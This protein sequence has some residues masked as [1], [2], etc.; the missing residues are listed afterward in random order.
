MKPVRLEFNR[1]CNTSRTEWNDNLRYSASLNL[2]VLSKMQSPPHERTLAIVGGG[3]STLAG[4]DI[5]RRWEGDVWG[6]N[7]T[8]GWL[9]RKGVSAT[10]FSIDALPVVK[11]QIEGSDG[12]I[13]ASHVHR[14]MF[15]FTLPKPVR[16]FHLASATGGPD[17]PSG[18]TSGSTAPMVA[19]HLGYRSIM[20]FGCEG[21]FEGQTH[22][23]HDEAHADHVEIAANGGR[24]KTTPEF[25][26][27][28]EELSEVMRGFPSQF[29]N[30]S[31]GLLEAMT[32]DPMWSVVGA[33]EH[34]CSTFSE[35][36]AFAQ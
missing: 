6:I 15:D 23:S 1:I 25:L 28:T 2:P 14:T 10:L 12:A 4:F 8:V 18:A 13:L 31:G 5:L 33:S 24:F 22:V 27:Q 9:A 20:F 19:L 34:L 7:S 30:C 21:S 3:P 36:V 16:V 29:H 32:A 17:W 11:S 35:Q 26:V